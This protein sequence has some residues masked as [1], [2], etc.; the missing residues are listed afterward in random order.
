MYSPKKF[1]HN[2]NESM[3]EFMRAHPFASLVCNNLNGLNAEHIPFWVR[4]ND[5]SKTVLCAHIA[6]ANPLW[7]ELQNGAAVLVLFQG[8]N[9]Y[10]SP[11]W[12]PSKKND[13]RVVPT[14]NYT[15]VHARGSIQ[16]IHDSQW[17]LSLLND[18]TD[19]HEQNQEQPWKVSDAPTGFI[20][21]QLPAIVGIEI[22]VNDLLGKFKLSQNQSVENRQGVK[23]G[24]TDINHKMSAI[25]D[26]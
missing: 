2:D 16:F 25:I 18:L 1:E 15:A 24:L 5:E 22:E 14:W 19:S 21:K 4:T 11:N 7:Q 13:S 20:E 26:I 6:K 12:Y 23:S 10:I 9:S 3:L 17:L 8:T